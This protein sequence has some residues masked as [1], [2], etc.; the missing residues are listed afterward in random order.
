MG[1]TNAVHYSG[2]SEVD[3]AD[4]I[5]SLIIASPLKAG[6]QAGHEKFIRYVASNASLKLTGTFISAD[7]SSV[8]NGTSLTIP[9]GSNHFVWLIWNGSS[10]LIANASD[11][12]NGTI[13]VAA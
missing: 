5:A 3:V 1:T 10:W 9:G 8:T 4:D 7:G 12:T 11:T 13:V 6:I 2:W